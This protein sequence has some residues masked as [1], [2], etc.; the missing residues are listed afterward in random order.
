MLT[1]SL[2]FLLA[3]LTGVTAP[4][5]NAAQPQQ[6]AVGSSAEM[7]SFK[8]VALAKADEDSGYAYMQLN[9]APGIPAFRF[10]T[11]GYADFGQVIPAPRTYRG[12]RRRE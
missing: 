5:A 2:L 8:L 7:V 6:A 11:A 3:I 10:V 4:A 9:A 1:R 12:D